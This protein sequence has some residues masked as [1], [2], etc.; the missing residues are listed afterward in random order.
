MD[1]SPILI[2]SIG[3]GLAVILLIVGI[4]SSFLPTNQQ[5]KNVSVN[6]S[7]RNT[8]DGNGAHQAHSPYR[9]AQCQS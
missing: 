4:V 6:T 9:L 2:L 3:G 7:T 5:L 1:I 8:Q